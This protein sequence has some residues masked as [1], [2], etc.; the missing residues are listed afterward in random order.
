M[1]GVSL[2]LSIGVAALWFRSHM[3]SDAVRW[4]NAGGWREAYSNRGYFVIKVMLGDYSQSTQQFQPPTYLREDLSQ[5]SP[6][7]SVKP[8]EIGGEPDD[9][10]AEWKWGGFAWYERRNARLS[11]LAGSA[12]IPFWS[13]SLLAAVPV[14]AWAIT[15]RRRARR[16]RFQGLCLTC[17]YDLRESPDRCPECG[18]V[19]TAGVIE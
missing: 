12:V 4:C 19:P 5:L 13:L 14:L 10:Y 1:A 11:T 7:H 9:A 2:L 6:P 18:T 16:P 8:Q 17:G 3:Y 15:Y